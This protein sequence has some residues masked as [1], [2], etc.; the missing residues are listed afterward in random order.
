MGVRFLDDK[1]ECIVLGDSCL[2]VWDGSKAKF[3]SSQD[4][5]QF[6]SFPDY[7][8]SSYCKDGKG[9]PKT[10]VEVMSD[11]TA[12]L[13]VSDPFSNFLIEKNKEAKLTE[14]IP[15]L[16]DLSSH[17]DF[18]SIVSDWR[19]EGMPND[20]TTLVVIKPSN[21]R[22]LEEGHIDNLEALI[23]QEEILTKRTKEK[24]EKK[25]DEIIEENQTERK[26]AI[27]VSQT[28]PQIEKVPTAQVEREVVDSVQTE[29]PIEEILQRIR[30]IH[31][32]NCVIYCIIM[33]YANV[34][35]YKA[36]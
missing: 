26:E 30:L 5:E 3:C 25:E 31:N 19:D 11:S 21:S 33:L 8:D 6:D 35:M 16:L 23:T 10:F 34:V 13:V 2:I 18:E 29:I 4:V 27:T 28:N 32:M 17:E 15:K 12:L 22:Q 9:Q 24:S 20:D 1:W 14:Y 36:T 7:F